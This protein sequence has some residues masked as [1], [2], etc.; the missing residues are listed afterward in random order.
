MLTRGFFRA[1]LAGGLVSAAVTV[2]PQ[3]A[4]AADGG[5]GRDA[6]TAIVAWN[7]QSLAVTLAEPLNPPLE[8]R[9]I[10]IE[11]AAV[12][13]AVISIIPRFEPYA[14]RV[15]VRR[16]ASVAAAADAAAHAVM[17]A[18]YPDQQASLDAF[19][20]TQLAAIPD[21]PAKS[22][23]QAAG[24]AAAAAILALRANDHSGDTVPYTPG[25]APGRWR[26]TPPAFKPAL[27]PG[28]GN[29]T[30][31]V[32]RS[33]SQYRPG[34]PPFLTSA[35]YTRDFNEIKAIGSATSTT[36]TPE[37]TT[38][39]HLWTVTGTQLWNQAVQ[40]A[41][42]TRGLGPAVTARDFAMLDLAGAD[43]FIAS[44]DAKYT[45]NQWRPVTAIQL[46]DTDGNPATAAD[47]TWT[48]L[49]TTPNFPDY[50]SGHAT[51]AGAAETVLSAL[52]GSHSGSFTF[53]NHANGLTWAYTSFADAATQVANSI[54]SPER[55][56]DIAAS[57]TDSALGSLRSLGQ[58]PRGVIASRMAA[59]T[60]TLAS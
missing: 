53:T 6:T 47:P 15:R 41:A 30:P 28:W 44:W 34:P 37:E 35:A 59:R 17:T 18:L 55:T 36:R 21:G 40:Q 9:N 2:T 33:G 60:R 3:P 13:D 23:G 10:A 26:P 39:A 19:E 49:L 32:L 5:P 45:Y 43:T 8:G 4:L 42:V 27:D 58:Q 51:Y 12:Y 20:A 38:I 48:P 54:R 11:S 24:E 25:T 22:S 46:A 56:G 1:V 50:L 31:F 29:V 7:A 52:L 14:V 16:P 57:S